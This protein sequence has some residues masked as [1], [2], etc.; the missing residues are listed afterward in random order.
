MSAGLTV[1]LFLKKRGD[2]H[3][4]L[5][6]VTQS[7][8][9]IVCLSAGMATS[10]DNID[11]WHIWESILNPFGM[12][13]AVTFYH[14]SLVS[15]SGRKAFE[16]RSIAALY[17][18]PAAFFAF[19]ILNQD[20][21]IGEYPDTE[22]GRYG[23]NLP[24]A[25]GIY[26]PIFRSLLFAFSVLTIVNFIQMYNRSEDPHLRRQALYF[27]FSS[28]IPLI[29]FSISILLVMFDVL[30]GVQLGLVAFSVAGAILTYG[31]LK[32]GLFDI[33]IIVKKTF[34]Y[35]LIAFPLL[36]LFRLIELGIS[37]LVS[38]TFFGGSLIVRLIAAAIVA[39]AFF[40]LRKYAV[41]IGDRLFPSFTEAVKLD[42]SKELAIYRRQLEHV[43]E[44]GK[45]SEKEERMLK[46]L[47]VDMGIS[48]ETHRRLESEIRADLEG[49]DAPGK[50]VTGT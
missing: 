2:D 11:A 26:W 48:D 14:F 10:S 49:P 12:L 36:G 45:T 30:I 29:G 37:Y 7:S 25:V 32:H 28:F 39:A 42:L 50:D 41:D 17:L 15:K 8:I 9:A 23:R 27:T 19:A 20:Y 4:R 46:Q 18:L 3:V 40:P 33:E 38:F 22:L 43:L 1:L 34:I 44:D 13:A 47:R 5:F 35:S 21:I 31:I 16:D 6:I 24:G